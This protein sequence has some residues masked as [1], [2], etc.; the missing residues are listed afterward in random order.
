MAL[1]DV[2]PFDWP[3]SVAANTFSNTVAISTELAWIA[4]IVQVSRTGTLEGVG[5]RLTTTGS[6]NVV[7]RVETVTAGDPS[8]TLLAT[9]AEVTFTP[10]SGAMNY[11]LL[12]TPV[13][14]TRGD[15]IAIKL[16][17]PTGS[18]R[19]VQGQA[20]SSPSSGTPF[21]RSSGTNVNIPP[22]VVLGYNDGSFPPL[23]NVRPLSDWSNVT[24]TSSSNPRH[25]GNRITLPFAARLG[26]F[27]V[28][29]TGTVEHTVTLT[30]AS[31]DVVFTHTVPASSASSALGRHY[32]L[33]SPVEVPAG[34]YYLYV[35]SA[36]SLVIT[37]HNLAN[38]TH[39]EAMPQGDSVVLVS[40]AGTSGAWTVNTSERFNI[41]LR[42]DAIETG[43]SGGYSRARVVNS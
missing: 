11:Q 23:T 22:C 20:F 24:L 21:I 35:A 43:G 41:G 37:K 9:G 15:L 2:E 31:D 19:S 12:G 7:F 10:T 36:S 18:S 5:W 14:V 16:L 3:V 30:D 1:I 8:G 26:G 33:A 32:L 27:W 38:S 40:R 17:I 25:V 28:A 13:A 39:M 6:G 42:L 34:T 29:T 4:A